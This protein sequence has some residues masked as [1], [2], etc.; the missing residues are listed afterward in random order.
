MRGPTCPYLAGST[1]FAPKGR[2]PSREES[3]PASAWH[4]C[5]F[6]GGVEAVGLTASGDFLGPSQRCCRFHPARRD[7]SR[8]EACRP[9]GRAFRSTQLAD[10]RSNTQAPARRGVEGGNPSAPSASSSLPSPVPP[11]PVSSLDSRAHA[12]P[13]RRHGCILGR[14][15][16]ELDPRA[17]NPRH[18]RVSREGPNYRKILGK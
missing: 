16:A 18:R 2:A 13:N 17:Q 5:A 14:F 7:L 9:P 6:G 11:S 3:A 1:C 4:L 8:T 12:A 10:A 15:S